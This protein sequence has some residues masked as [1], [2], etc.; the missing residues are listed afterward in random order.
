MPRQL[1]PKNYTYNV[2]CPD[3][4]S[5]MDIRQWPTHSSELCVE[6]NPTVLIVDLSGI[7]INDLGLM[8]PGTIKSLPYDTPLLPASFLHSLSLP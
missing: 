5:L 8:T 2:V 7:N 4:L 6:N 3:C 1:N